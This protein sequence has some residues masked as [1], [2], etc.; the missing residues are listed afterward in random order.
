MILFTFYA[1]YAHGYA[2]ILVQPGKTDNGL[3]VSPSFPGGDATSLTATPPSTPASTSTPTS[4]ASASVGGQTPT[5]GSGQY[6]DGTYK[7][8]SVDA[9]YGLVQVQAVIQSG[10]IADVQFLSYPNDR[11]NSVRISAYATPILTQEAIQAQSANV[12]IVS[13]ATLTSQAFQQS[14]ASA[15]A[16]AKN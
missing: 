13:G 5:P 16:Q 14:L 2:L 11:Q 1:L 4:D 8:D 3:I 10:Q 7:G 6:K 12:D 9:Y 15:L